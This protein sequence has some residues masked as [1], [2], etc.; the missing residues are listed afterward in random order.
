MNKRALILVMSLSFFLQLELFGKSV[1][2]RSKAG[3]AS[4]WTFG[5]VP[6]NVMQDFD[7]G[8]CQP[9]ES[10][11]VVPCDFSIA[12]WIFTRSVAPF[13]SIVEKRSGSP[14]R[15]YALFT[16]NGRLAFEMAD[17]GGV[18]NYFSEAN[19][20]DGEWHQVMVT[21]DRKAAQGMLFVDGRPVLTFTPRPGVMT[22]AADLLVGKR[23]E[24]GVRKVTLHD[25]VLA[26]ESIEGPG[27][28]PTAGYYDVGIIP[29]TAG[30]CPA[31]S[32]YI[33]IYM[34]DEDNDNISSMSGWVGPTTQPATSHVNGTRLGFCR[35]DG[36]QFVN[37]GHANLIN[38]EHVAWSP[39]R[40]SV[41]A[42][43]YSLLKLGTQCPSSAKEVFAHIDNEDN[44]NQNSVSGN[45]AP[46]VGVPNADLYFCMFTPSI[47][48]P[49]MTDFPQIGVS[50]GVFGG[51]FTPPSGTGH[52]NYWLQTGYVFTDDE[53]KNNDNYR[54]FPTGYTTDDVFDFAAGVDSFHNSTFYMAKV[55]NA[56]CTNPCPTGGVY[57]G[58]NCFMYAVPGNVPFIWGGNFY[59][60]R[61]D[62]HPGS[63]CPHMVHDHLTNTWRPA[64]FDGANCYIASANG[65]PNPFIWSNN[66]YISRA[67]SNCANPC[68]YGGTFDGANCYMFSWPG[69]TPFIWS[70]NA[71][72]A[73]VWSHPN[74]PCPH[75]AYNLAT[76]ASVTPG[77][78]G[79]NCVVFMNPGNGQQ[80][81]IYANKYY[82][83]PACKP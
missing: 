8:T 76:G 12:V 37:L 56:I 82:L 50:Y 10:G 25:R 51:R 57:D 73:A 20:A 33:Q 67:C 59:Y 42:Y 77:Y 18:A 71:Y 58:A 52:R 5:D 1:T 74:G 38:W 65:G 11:T 54:V 45:F 16:T 75:A 7:L 30:A 72:Y 81:F 32:E 43:T 19:I 22:N 26:V 2:E 47:G 28:E 35:V 66:Y 4:L 68:P 53:D 24:G 48:G 41:G 31:G 46:N 17:A 40:A 80:P 39:T 21:V 70:G 34:D 61:V 69:V 60:G 49:T 27:L 83:T 44:N 62:D 78:D 3:P 29:E 14:P 55:R 13:Q 9:D 15:G 6:A 36:N 79:A 64:S 63:P 23:F